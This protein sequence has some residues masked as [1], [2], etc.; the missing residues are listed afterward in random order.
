VA[1]AVI[2]YTDRSR[3]AWGDTDASGRIY[4]ASIFRFVEAAE[5][6]LRRG[7]DLMDD[8]GSYPRRHVEVDYLDVLSWDDEVET[9]ISV[10]RVGRTS[11]TW[12]WA[13]RSGERLCATGSHTVVKLGPDGRPE[14]LPDPLRRALDPV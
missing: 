10:E 7:L 3:I 4:F 6:G 5:T 13:V 2:S 12:T 8:W 14:P 1:G 9:T 11:L